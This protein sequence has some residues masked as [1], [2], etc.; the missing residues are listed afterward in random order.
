MKCLYGYEYLYDW[1]DFD[2]AKNS[3]NSG[4]NEFIRL[5]EVM[6]Q[7]RSFQT[8]AEYR[9]FVCPECGTVKAERRW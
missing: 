8:D 9:L 6:R 4:D 3:K 2:D 5:K 7:H 1:E